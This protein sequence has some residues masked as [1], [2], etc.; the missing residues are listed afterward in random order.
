MKKYLINNKNDLEEFKNTE[1][2]FGE[3]DETSFPEFPYYI[4]T[5]LKIDY[6]GRYTICIET[7]AI[8]DFK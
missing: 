2:V 3:I 6:C 1:W 7:V 8:N 4:I 5:R